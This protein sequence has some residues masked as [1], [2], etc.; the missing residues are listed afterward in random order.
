MKNHDIS[1]PV[2]RLS[3]ADKARRAS[4]T[5]RVAMATIEAET[6]ARR[7][8]TARLRAARMTAGKAEDETSI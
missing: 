1:K 5:T 6:E 3:D 4:E 7:A 2:Q 8:K